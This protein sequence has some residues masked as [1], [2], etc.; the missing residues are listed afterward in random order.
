[1]R[2]HLLDEYSEVKANLDT[3]KY[4]LDQVTARQEAISAESSDIEKERFAAEEQARTS[5]AQFS[6]AVDFMGELDNQRTTLELQR[7]ELRTELNRAREQAD[8]DRIA[9]HDL[10]IQF[11][12]RRS[13][14]ESAAQGLE[15]MQSQLR[16]FRS[17]EQRDS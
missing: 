13:S 6:Q 4:Q 14:K 16:H 1:M 8:Q 11:E 5:Q 10:A 2:R 3:A 9:A 17:R 15:R 7:D 12:T